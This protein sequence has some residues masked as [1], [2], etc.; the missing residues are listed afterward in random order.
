MWEGGWLGF[1]KIHIHSIH[2]KICTRIIAFT[3]LFAVIEKKKKHI[4]QI[5][6]LHIKKKKSRQESNILY[7]FDIIFTQQLHV[8][9]IG[10]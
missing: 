3:D 10:L 2:N 7:T 1:V 6:I 9:P 5:L 8:Q 4:K